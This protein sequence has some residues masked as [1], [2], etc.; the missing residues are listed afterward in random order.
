M[1]T[2][3]FTFGF[4][5]VHSVGGFT[6]DKDVVVKITSEDPRQTMFD[7]FGRAWAMQYDDLD[8]IKLGYYPRGVKD[9]QRNSCE[10]KPEPARN[11][12]TYLGDSV[13]AQINEHG[14]LV[15]TTENGV[16]ED[17]SNQIVMEPEVYEAL[18]LWVQRQM[19]AK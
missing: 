1:R 9:L 13:Y 10:L 19:E 16:P 2:S 17:P 6:Y 11:A 5:H 12:K 8:E 14:Q 7:T 4:G 15:L 3:Y 18:T